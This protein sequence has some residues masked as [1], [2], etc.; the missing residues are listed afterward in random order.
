MP[1]ILSNGVFGSW[2]WSTCISWNKPLTRDGYNRIAE[3]HRHL[4]EDVR[5]GVVEGIAIA[6][7]EG[8]R[9]EN[10]EYIY[11]KKRLREIDKKLRY[12][13]SLLKDVDVVDVE[14]IRADVVDFG[15]TITICDENGVKKVWTLVGVGEAD[16][17]RGTISY[18][19]PVAKAF[20]GKKVGDFVDIKRPAGYMEYELL[21]LKYGPDK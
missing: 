15:A 8:D 18:K 13:T 10:A 9:S 4:L 12:Y 3:E 14:H 16:V 11:G 17:D 19:S 6:A 2:L 21:G 1:S 5:P 20:I 7:A